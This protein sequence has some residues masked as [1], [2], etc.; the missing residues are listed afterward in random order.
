MKRLMCFGFCVILLLSMVF[1]VSAEAND[2]DKLREDI[3]SAME[4]GERLNISEYKLSREEMEE[5]YADLFHRG[6]LP[7]YADAFCDWTAAS[8]GTIAA[9]SLRDLRKRSFSED[10]YERA[11][12]ELIAQTCHEGMTDLQKVLSVHD[13]IVSHAKYSFLDA[14]NNGYHALVKGETA[15]YGYAQLF[16]RVMQRLGIPCQIVICDDTGEGL[17]HAWNVVEVDGSW[18]HLDLTWDDPL[19]DAP[20]RALHTYFLKTD[21]EFE[22]TLGHDFGWAPEVECDDNTFSSG[23]LWDDVDSP[24]IFLNAETALLRRLDL[25]G[26]SIYTRNPQTGEEKRLHSVSDDNISTSLC[27]WNERIWFNTADTIYSMKLDGTDIKTEYT[28]DIEAEDAFI[29]GFQVGDGIM[30]VS[31]LRFQDEEY[32]ISEQKVELA[33]VQYHEHAYTASYVSATC[34]EG[35]YTQ[36]SCICGITYQIERSD[37][38]GHQFTEGNADGAPGQHCVNC[39]YIYEEAISAT[40]ASPTAPDEVTNRPGSFTPMVLAIAIFAVIAITAGILL[41]TRKR[42]SNQ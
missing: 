34:E 3:V 9:I 24:I 29:Y 11:M 14:T 17:G 20:C 26:S 19:P 4:T 1:S 5:I 33:D 13:Y 32:Q 18:Y 37:P 25:H 2:Y 35:G 30:N 8:D 39:D 10:H 31:L 21:R 16:L 38:T 6:L 7:W 12:A 41:S 15:C 40:E 42:K 36:K 23:N 28:R 22:Q 27:W